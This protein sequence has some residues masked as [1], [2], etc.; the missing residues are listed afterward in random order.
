MSIVSLRPTGVSHPVNSEFR[1][2]NLLVGNNVEQLPKGA[3]FV[4]REFAYRCF[5]ARLTCDDSAAFVRYTVVGISQNGAFYG[6]TLA[7]IYIHFAAWQATLFLYP[8]AVVFSFVANRFWSFGGR[9]LTPMAFRKYLLV[10]AVTYPI[11]VVLTWAQEQAGIPSWLA[12]L[13]TLLTAVG[14]IFLL[15]NCWVFDRA[16]AAPNIP[17]Q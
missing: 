7:L 11:A 17:S 15:L 10:Y 4:L 1:Y 6:L 5:R 14:G 2:V 3:F 16:A 8:I 12:S 9:K 13:I